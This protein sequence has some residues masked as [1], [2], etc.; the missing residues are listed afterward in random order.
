VWGTLVP[1]KETGHWSTCASR[2]GNATRI[3]AMGSARR[4]LPETFTTCRQGP[5][6]AMVV[7]RPQVI[8]IV[9]M[10][11]A[12]DPLKNT[13]CLKTTPESH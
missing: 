1:G 8:G 10:A 7:R 9:A 4:S 12:S 6:T 3:S 2:V 5:V 13:H 11:M